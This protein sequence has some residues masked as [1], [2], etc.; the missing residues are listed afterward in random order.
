MCSEG[1]EC[2][3]G[4]VIFYSLGNFIFENDTTTHQ[5]ADFYEKYGLALTTLRWGP[6]W[7]R[8]AKEE[9]GRTGRK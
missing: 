5:P 2:Y 1:I 7:I 8:E 4:G 9:R 6:E 3:N